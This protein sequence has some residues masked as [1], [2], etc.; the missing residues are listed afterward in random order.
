[1]RAGNAGFLRGRGKS[2]ADAG[3][4]I[5]WILKTQCNA[6]LHLMATVLVVAAG[7]LFQVSSLEWVILVLAM[8][9][10]WSAEAFNS[11]LERLADAVTEEPHPFVGQAKDAAAGAVLLASTGAAIVG[12][13]LFLPYVLDFFR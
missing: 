2:F 11:A 4:G 7:W 10:V 9:L 13:L 12:V 1:M 6:K 3:R 5:A 8:S